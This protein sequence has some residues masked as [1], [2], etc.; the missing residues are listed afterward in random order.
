MTDTIDFAGN[1]HIG[2]YTRVFDDV[3]F[4]PPEAPEEYIS[5]VGREL[6]VEVAETTI[7]G[8]SIVGSLLVGNSCGFVVSGLA[9]AL[10]IEFLKGY[11]KVMLLER[12]MNA[13][14][15]VILV[16][17]DLAVVHPDMPE[18]IAEE[19]STFLEVPVLM[20][21]IGGVAT[22]GMAAVATN[23][24][25]LLPPRSSRQEIEAI[26]EY[27]DLPVGTGTINMGSN[28]IG[29]GLIANS[30]GYLAGTAT[31]GYELGRIEEV[32]GF[33]E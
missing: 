7:Q 4:V 25:F 23:K 26:E 29:T 8:S 32:L 17:D 1:E 27:T 28:L 13:A 21:P 30:K 18:R 14:G 33:V 20:M 15:N 5:A 3:A 24:G 6:H 12:G 10:E 31:S 2:V 19:I 11:R 9:S 22:V 16:N